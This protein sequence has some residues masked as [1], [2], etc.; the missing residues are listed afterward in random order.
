MDM[1]FNFDNSGC[2]KSINLSKY[3]KSQATSIHLSLFSNY[4]N[5]SSIEFTRFDLSNTDYFL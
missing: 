2:L 4:S 3:F 5:I 1:S